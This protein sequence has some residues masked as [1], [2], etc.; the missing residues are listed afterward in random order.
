ML[1][2]L[3]GRLKAALSQ[4]EQMVD[5]FLDQLRSDIKASLVDLKGET[6]KYKGLCRKH[7]HRADTYKIKHLEHE[8]EMKDRISQLEEAMDRINL[9][10]NKN[11][12]LRFQKHQMAMRYEQRMNKIENIITKILPNMDTLNL[13]QKFHDRSEQ[14]DTIGQLLNQTNENVMNRSLSH[15]SREYATQKVAP[16][17]RQPAVE[18]SELSKLNQSCDQRLNNQQ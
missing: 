12:E 7:Y 16:E 10:A 18:A 13:S 2:G 5:V 9:Q 3:I 4:N 15:V 11:E 1:Q 8:F 17:H 6:E 14:L